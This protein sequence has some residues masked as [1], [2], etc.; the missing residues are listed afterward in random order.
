MLV[1]NEEV[2]W[3]L[4]RLLKNIDLLTDWEKKFVRNMYVLRGYKR[5]LTNGQIAKIVEIYDE[6]D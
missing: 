1:T 5:D 6:I 4:Q 2:D 3:I